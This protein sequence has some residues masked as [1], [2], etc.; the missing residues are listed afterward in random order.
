MLAL[1]ALCGDHSKR[2]SSTAESKGAFL[3]SLLPFLL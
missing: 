2:E 1:Y 3:L